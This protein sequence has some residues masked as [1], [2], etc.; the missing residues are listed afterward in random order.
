MGFPKG[1]KLLEKISLVTGH[2]NA[3]SLQKYWIYWQLNFDMS[4]ATLA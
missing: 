4:H 3:K 2:N 1:L